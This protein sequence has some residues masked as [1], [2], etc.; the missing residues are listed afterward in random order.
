MCCITSNYCCIC[1]VYYCYIWQRI[2]REC[3]ICCTL[4]RL[5]ITTRCSGEANSIGVTSCL[6]R[7]YSDRIGCK[8]VGQTCTAC[9]VCSP[10]HGVVGSCI[11]YIRL[12]QYIS[13]QTDWCYIRNC[14]SRGVTNFNGHTFS[15]RTAVCI[16]DGY[17]IRC[18]CCDCRRCYRAGGRGGVPQV[19]VVCCSALGICGECRG[20]VFA[21]GCR[22]GNS[23]CKFARLCYCCNRSCRTGIC[24]GNGY[25][26]GSCNCVCQVLSCRIVVPSVG[27]RLC[28]AYYFGADCGCLAVTSYCTCI[29]RY[30][31]NIW[32]GNFCGFDYRTSLCIGDGDSIFSSDNPS[33]V[34]CVVSVAPNVCQWCGSSADRIFDVSRSAVASCSSCR[35]FRG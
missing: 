29:K 20:C 16:V 21:D 23:H 26:I 24:I 34:L 33:Q 31:K 3:N 10:F 22:T 17:R 4:E 28:S 18:F 7:C 14:Y 8:V 19:C 25:R 35:Q 30:G 6:G 1:I 15:N 5:A 9:R 11:G 32:L 13:A 12:Q 2:Y 27:I